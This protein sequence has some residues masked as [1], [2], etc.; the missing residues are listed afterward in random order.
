MYGSV[1]DPLPVVGFITPVG[2][3]GDAG[4][5]AHEHAR[6]AAQSQERCDGMLLQIRHI[7]R[8]PSKTTFMS[9]ISACVAT[10]ANGNPPVGF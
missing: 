8:V 3:L 1:H 9:V 4:A 10:G 5:S 6:I 7:L 2:K